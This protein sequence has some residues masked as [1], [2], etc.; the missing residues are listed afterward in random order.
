MASKL[1][2]IGTALSLC[3]AASNLASQ[4]SGP[5][6][7]AG[8]RIRVYRVAELA[9]HHITGRFVACNTAYLSLVSDSGRIPMNIPYAEITRLERSTGKHGHTLLGLGIGTAAGLGVGLAGA[10]SSESSLIHFGPSEVVFVTIGFGAAGA[11]IGHLMQSES[12]VEVP[13]A[14]FDIPPAAPTDTAPPAIAPIAAG[15]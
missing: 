9:D 1:L 7:K 14:R 6:L 10:A 12:W 2:L 4:E 3:L 11:L 15:P 8:D 13:L 5:A